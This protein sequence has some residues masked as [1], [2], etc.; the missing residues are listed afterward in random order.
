[1][2]Q[3]IF[4][5]ALLAAPIG[6]HSETL[7]LTQDQDLIRAAKQVLTTLQV[8]SFRAGREFCGLLGRDSDGRIISTRPKRGRLDS[9]LPNEFRNPD[10]T[11]LASFHTHAAYDEDA[12]SEVPSFEDLSADIAE[13]LVG[14]VATP[15]GR[16][17]ISDP[18]KQRV[19]QLCGLRCLPQDRLFQQGDWGNIAKSY[20]LRQ[21]KQRR[22]LY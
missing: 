19:T 16:F 22:S 1:M 14:F 5:L 10:V 21:L 7:R 18:V 20:S 6:A 2:K 13:G 4:A 15:G 12:D 9:C 8:R 11:P 17:W 3:M